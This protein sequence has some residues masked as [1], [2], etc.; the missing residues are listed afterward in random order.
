[1][2]IMMQATSFGTEDMDLIEVE[3]FLSNLTRAG[4]HELSIAT[5]VRSTRAS[6]VPSAAPQH[7]ACH[8]AMRRRYSSSQALV[9]IQVRFCRG[10]S[11]RCFAPSF[12]P[13]RSSP[14]GPS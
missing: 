3:N 8:P 13:G 9:N 10:R 2:L 6:P 4:L 7:D 12:P 14:P 5:G 1:M 11:R